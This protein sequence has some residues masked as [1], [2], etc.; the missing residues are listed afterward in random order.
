MTTLNGALMMKTPMFGT[1][2][3]LLLAACTRQA[4]E[5][6]T[7]D[8]HELIQEQ[9][10]EV[11]SWDSSAS[12]AC[13]PG[14]KI[15]FLPSS[16]GNEQLPIAF[17]AV[18]CDLRYSVAMNNGGVVCIHS[19]IQVDKPEAPHEPGSDPAKADGVPK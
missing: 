4:E 2:A 11:K 10:C 17:V 9:I 14:Q 1:F 19:K 8:S 5:H 15:T 18:N 3:V 13:K 7:P 12:A 6:S 16:W